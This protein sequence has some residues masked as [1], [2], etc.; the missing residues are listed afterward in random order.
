MRLSLQSL[1]KTTHRGRVRETPATCLECLDQDKART[2]EHLNLPGRCSL[3]H[4]RR[5]C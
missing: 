3:W 2:R 4:L 1:E 5:P